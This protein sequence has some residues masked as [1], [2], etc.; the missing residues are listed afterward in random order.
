M[1]YASIAAYMVY[2]FHPW[3][4]NAVTISYIQVR[5]TH[6]HTRTAMSVS[7]SHS[8]ANLPSQP[9]PVPA[10]LPLS[11]SLSLSPSFS[12][13]SSH[14]PILPLILSDPEGVGGEHL[15][16]HQADIPPREP[17]RIL[18]LRG[19]DLGRMG[20][21]PCADAAGGVARGVLPQNAAN[22]EQDV[23]IDKDVFLHLVSL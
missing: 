12:H 21:L 20:L 8:L 3:V 13:S 2:V 6:N 4:V 5:H 16:Q 1:A 9:S 14:S 22:L 23:L 7:L 10:Q 11:L 19:G 15:A 17:D 18:A